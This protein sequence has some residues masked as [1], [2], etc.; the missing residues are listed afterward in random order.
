MSSFSSLG[1]HMVPSLSEERLE[2]QCRGALAREGRLRRRQHQMLAAAAVAAVFVVGLGLR[3]LWSMQAGG[4]PTVAMD[5]AAP[6]N[7][8]SV[9]FADGSRAFLGPDA[10]MRVAQLTEKAMAFEVDRGKVTFD[11]VPRKERHFTVTAKGYTVRVTGTRFLVELLEEKQGSRLKVEVQR[12]QVEVARTDNA[13]LVVAL[14]QGGAFTEP[15]SP[16]PV[17]IADAGVESAE[18][19]E[20]LAEADAG[21]PL[22][23]PADWR[24]VRRSQGA[25]AGYAT[26]GNAG[27][28]RAIASA[29]AAELFE[30]F[31]LA[32]LAGQPSQ[33]AR[34][35]D[36]LRRGYRSDSRAGLAAFELGR[37]R[38]DR[39]GDPAGAAEAL[40]DALVLSP[41]AS[42]R[43]DAEAR[44]IEAFDRL[45]WRD[46]CEAARASHL[47]RYPEGPHRARVNRSCG[48]R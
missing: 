9:T 25:K 43:E 34:A 11:V 47:A 21:S 42:F 18:T 31:E 35:L 14:K 15:A 19:G 36:R 20:E 32:R 28:G 38:L 45:G 37:L 16:P 24:E 33:A 10:R 8:Q 27:F 5:L 40:Q 39:L 26:L 29:G 22:A 30:L 41:S 12:G 6:T 23:A 4:T 3:G 48:H 2:A 46:R 44:R 13:Q 17:G 1:Q 7:T